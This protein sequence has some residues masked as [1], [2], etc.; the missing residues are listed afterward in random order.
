MEINNKY[1][2][3]SAYTNNNSRNSKWRR[4]ASWNGLTNENQAGASN[5]SNNMQNNNNQ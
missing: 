1:T 2:F 3:C 5:G 4:L